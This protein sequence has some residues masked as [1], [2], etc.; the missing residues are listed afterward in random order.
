MRFTLGTGGMAR[1]YVGEWDFALRP[2]MA[3]ASDAYLARKE[4]P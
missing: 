4:F 3:K 1:E 2:L